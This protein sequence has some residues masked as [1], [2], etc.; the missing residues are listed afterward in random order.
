M[1]L[2]PKLLIYDL[3][4]TP[5]LAWTY[6]MWDANVLKIERHSYLMC[7]SYMWY[8]EKKV[9]SVSQLDF[10]ARYKADPYDDYDVVRELRSLLDQADIAIAYNGKRFD[11][12]VS[13]TRIMYHKMDIPSPFKS[14]DPL[15]V[16]K[17]K[18]KLPSNS[19]DNLCKYF[20]IKGKTEAV[21][22]AL[23]H[24]CVNGDKKAWK[25]MVTYCNN[26]VRMLEDVYKRLLPLT[27]NHPNL[28]VYSQDES[29]CPKCQ[30]H[31]YTYEGYRTTNAMTYRRLRCKDCG[32]W[33]SD[34]K[35][36]KDDFKKPDYTNY[37]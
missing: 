17:S 20:G 13:M 22:G 1:H 28:S 12:K 23:W 10:A 27:T 18:L 30:S 31:N 9:H 15:Q 24:D 2:K 26:D 29:A 34:R 16:A 37:N 14:V 6:K 3:E 4:V 32:G 19:M 11:D 21:H 25:K 8:G 7:F 35:S 36:L 5:M 33:F